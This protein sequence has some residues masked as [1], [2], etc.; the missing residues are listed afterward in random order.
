MA[1]VPAFEEVT[2]FGDFAWDSA[3]FATT[4]LT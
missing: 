2:V 1:V 3:P 4:S